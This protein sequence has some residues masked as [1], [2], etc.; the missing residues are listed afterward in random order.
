MHSS[1]KARTS[2]GTLLLNHEKNCLI[3]ILMILGKTCSSQ[4]SNNAP[5]ELIKYDSIAIINSKFR[6]CFD[7]SLC[8]KIE[9]KN[10]YLKV[11]DSLKNHRIV[12]TDSI[13]EPCLSFDSCLMKTFNEGYKTTFFNTIKC[14]KEF[15][16]CIKYHG[17]L[18]LICIKQWIFEDSLIPKKICDLLNSNI[19]FSSHYLFEPQIWIGIQYKNAIILLVSD[20]KKI[21]DANINK[22]STI[23]KDICHNSRLQKF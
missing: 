7:T 9:Y 12:L 18:S 17:F 1:D 23:I 21:W 16:Y 4:I 22:V 11:F 3:I 5:A 15:Y 8:N 19:K 6:T 10:L 13:L 14:S 20:D 2:R